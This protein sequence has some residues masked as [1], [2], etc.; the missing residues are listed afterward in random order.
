MNF[1][2]SPPPIY[3]TL[4]TFCPHE[5]RAFPLADKIKGARGRVGVKRED[6]RR[7]R[8]IVDFYPSSLQVFLTWKFPGRTVGRLVNG[9]AF[10]VGISRCR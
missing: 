8:R 4:A 9:I 3:E 5:T 10:T 1:F 2:L 6:A 7:T